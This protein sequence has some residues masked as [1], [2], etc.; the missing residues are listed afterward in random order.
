MRFVH[1]HGCITDTIISQHWNTRILSP[2]ETDT[3]VHDNLAWSGSHIQNSISTELL[4]SLSD[5]TSSTK[6]G[7]TTLVVLLCLIHNDEHEDMEVLKKN[8][9][10]RKLKSFLGEDVVASCVCESL[11][12]TEAFSQDFLH[13]VIRIFEMSTEYCFL[14]WAMKQSSF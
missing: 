14:D 13:T 5:E 2:D 9:K 12:A 11:D 6:N 7:S 3:F 4:D 10:Q 8:L 1:H